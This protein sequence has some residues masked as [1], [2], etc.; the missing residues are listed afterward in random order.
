MFFC[1]IQLADWI[2]VEK[3]ENKAAQRGSTLGYKTSEDPSLLQSKSL[4]MLGLWA[5]SFYI[6][7]PKK[8]Q[9]F[10][11]FTIRKMQIFLIVEKK[12]SQESL[13]SWDPVE[14]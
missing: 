8:N 9:V 12:K 6:L 1:E 3:T 11:P 13:P 7:G 14:R 10:H 2:L 5:G 4:G